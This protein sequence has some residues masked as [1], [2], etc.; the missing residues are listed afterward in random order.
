MF[1]WCVLDVGTRGHST[2]IQMNGLSFS[3]QASV[4]K[5]G[6]LIIAHEATAFCNAVISGGSASMY[7]APV[8]ILNI[9]RHRNGAWTNYLVL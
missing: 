4:Q 8:V 7:P 6:R 1:L 5:T 2:N 3:P 9:V